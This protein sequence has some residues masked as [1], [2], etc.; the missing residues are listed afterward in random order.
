MSLNKKENIKQIENIINNNE[1]IKEEEYAYIIDS[2]N[3][4]KK[5]N[6]KN[7][8]ENLF[9]F[10]GLQLDTSDED[11]V[12]QSTNSSINNSVGNASLD[13]NAQKLMHIFTE[14]LFP[15][16]L[17]IVGFIT[18]KDFVNNILLLLSLTDKSLWL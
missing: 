4:L 13:N 18:F 9:K 16:V 2:K 1:T 10:C 3:I 5:E 15:I 14:R 6:L 7:M 12:N 8:N 17:L 11:I